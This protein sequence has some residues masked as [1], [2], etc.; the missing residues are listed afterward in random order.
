MLAHF[1]LMHIS[2]EILNLSNP[3]DTKTSQ[4]RRKNVLI[5]VSKTSQIGLKWKSRRPF[6]K[7]SSGRVPTSSRRL[8]RDVL[9]TSSRK[10]PQDILQETSSR[11]LPRDAPKT[12]LRRLK[13]SKLFLVN[14]K[15]YLETMNFLSRY[16]LNYFTCYHSITIQTN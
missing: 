3:A 8:L 16:V 10:H 11:C 13:T 5:L 4:R 14:K 9:K 6:F 2:L 12:Y 1:H 15:G 7:T